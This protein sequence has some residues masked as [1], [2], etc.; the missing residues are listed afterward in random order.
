KTFSEVLFS[1][2]ALNLSDNTSSSS[3]M[4]SSADHWTKK[5]FNLDALAG[6]QN[7]LV[8]IKATNNDGNNLYLDNIEFF[9]NDDPT[10]PVI[11]EPFLVYTIAG[12]TYLTF[13]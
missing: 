13:N 8:A 4:P 9:E 2:S 1:N 7:V 12:Q 11:S 5:Y 10:P 6:K 3:W